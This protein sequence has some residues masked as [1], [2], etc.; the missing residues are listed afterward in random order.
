MT[1]DSGQ[2]KAQPHSR[3]PTR[4][5]GC[6]VGHGRAAD[7]PP[8]GRDAPAVSGV[9]VTLHLRDGGTGGG[10]GQHRQD[11]RFAPRCICTLSE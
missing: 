9:A 2:E 11:T 5:P 4:A 6:L 7:G 10:G 8:V 3:R 1:G